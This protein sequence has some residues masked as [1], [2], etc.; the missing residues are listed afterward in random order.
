[1]LKKLKNVNAEKYRHNKGSKKKFDLLYYQV[2]KVKNSLT[3]F[4]IIDMEKS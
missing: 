4:E 2:G 1:M 3:F